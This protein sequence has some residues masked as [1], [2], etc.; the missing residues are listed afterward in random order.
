MMRL[1]ITGIFVCWMFIC[2]VSIAQTDTL[3]NRYCS[4]LFQT[5]TLSPEDVAT[6]QT[7]LSSAGQWPDIDYK[8]DDLAGWKIGN[9]LIRV[10][11]MAKVWSFP[12]SPDYHSAT[13]LKQV[14]L[15]LDHWLDHPYQSSNWWHNE[16]GVPQ[17]MRDIIILLRAELQGARLK[18]SLAVMAQLRVH[19]DYVGGNLVWCADLGLHYGALTNDQVLIQRCRDLIVK[20]ISIT[21]GEGI[22][23]DYSFHQH[24]KRLQMYQYGKAY[25]W[26]STR[27]AWQCRE[28][29]WAFPKDKVDILSNFILQGWQWMAR[30][31]YTVPGTMDRSSSR[32]GELK[33]P[34][35]RLLIPF[36]I[37]LS[38]EHAKA[39]QKMA[40]IQNGKGALRGYRAYPYSDFA[41]YHRPGFSFFLKTISS[42][43]L[44][45]EHIN[46]EN[47]LGKLLNSGDAYLIRNGEEYFNLMPAW[48]WTALP[49]VTTFKEADHIDKQAF[50]GSISDGNMGF[51]AMDYVLQNKANTQQIAARKL[52]ACYGDQ[53]VCLISKITNEGVNDTLY[54]ALDQCRW[55]GDV[56]V[57]E[58]KNVLAEGIHQLNDV[59]WIYHAG[60][61][62]IP[63]QPAKVK[64]QL[65]ETKASWT[66]I[67]VSE[68]RD[69]LS[70]KV[71]LP[72]L[73]HDQQANSGTG[74]VLS[75]AKN[76]KEAAKIAA[77]PQWK[78][79]QNDT[80]CQAV[81]LSDGTQMV[82]FYKAGK[83]RLAKQGEVAV[84]QPCLLLL[85][86]NTVYASDPTHQGRALRLSRNGKSLTLQLPTNGLTVQDI[87]K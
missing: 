2:Q 43:T 48:D 38:P 87:I 62:Y 20:E 49:G 86:G 12:K 76:P 59:R 11:E 63:L 27:V 21:T 50:V 4:Y 8:N 9:H 51:S 60:F 39:F 56:T 22:Q 16:I 10:R 3:L 19:D 24:G 33:S 65:K 28:T 78:I 84:D 75:L 69:T 85:K 74:Y 53:V 6:W 81:Q 79:L 55:R 41:A 80:Q 7:S 34:D 23:P 42:R 40:A 44:A 14:Y 64:L 82:A 77:H 66:S 73:L 29:T 32:V 46:G 70:E 72:L 61:A 58:T 13:L 36:A 30:G 26:E 15:A 35:M 25:L 57:N 5:S 45:T 31:V 71:F 83:L 52:W 37:D 17:Y 47:R 54:T 1:K 67:N 18:K 68:I